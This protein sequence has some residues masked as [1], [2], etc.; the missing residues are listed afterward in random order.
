MDQQQKSM[1][2]PGK[3]ADGPHKGFQS[4]AALKAEEDRDRPSATGDEPVSGLVNDEEAP[5]PAEVAEVK[6]DDPMRLVQVR[7]RQNIAPFIYGKG[8]MYALKANQNTMIPIC[9][10]NHLEEKGLL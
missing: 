9:V 7:A 8:K 6:R 3:A 10:R 4:A 5:P 2:R 1:V